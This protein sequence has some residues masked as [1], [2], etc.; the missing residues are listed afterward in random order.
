M[1]VDLKNKVKMDKNVSSFDKEKKDRKIRI[2]RARLSEK[3][4]F[5]LTLIY[6][7]KY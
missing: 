6:Y 3:E 4:S 5:F 1:Y 2:E 7:K